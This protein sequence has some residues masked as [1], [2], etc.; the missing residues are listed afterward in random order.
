MICTG[1]FL[2]LF[3]FGFFRMLGGWTRKC[4]SK[5]HSFVLLLFLFFLFSNK[6]AFFH[7]FLFLRTLVHE[8][9]VFSTKKIVHVCLFK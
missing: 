5:T 1:L 2:S 3:N 9:K 7:L 4:V 8:R 6:R